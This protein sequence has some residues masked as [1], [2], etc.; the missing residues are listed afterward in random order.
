MTKEGLSKIECWH[1]DQHEGDYQVFTGD[2]DYGTIAIYHIGSR[3]VDSDGEPLEELEDCIAYLTCTKGR[4]W[5]FWYGHNIT[6]EEKGFVKG[7]A[8]ALKGFTLNN[9]E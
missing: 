5:S 8:F 6:P 2:R 9:I 4:R 1:Q 7:V 3:K